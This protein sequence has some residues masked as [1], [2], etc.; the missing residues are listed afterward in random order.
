MLGRLLL[1]ARTVAAQEGLDPAG[2]RVVIN[3]GPDGCERGGE[4]EAVSECEVKG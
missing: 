3:D 2:Y 1:A 4:R